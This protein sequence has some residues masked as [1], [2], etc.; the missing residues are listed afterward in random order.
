MLV[1]AFL[2]LTWGRVRA[3]YH[4]P[5]SSFPLAPVSLL[6]HPNNRKF[7]LHLLQLGSK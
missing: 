1:A 3:A 4:E 7:A 6:P 5:V 2:T